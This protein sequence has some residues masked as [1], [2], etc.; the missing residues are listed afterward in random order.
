MTLERVV[1]PGLLPGADDAE[2]VGQLAGGSSVPA[3]AA[4]S[5]RRGP[6]R[7]EQHESLD[8]GLAPTRGALV[9]SQRRLGRHLRTGNNLSAG[10]VP[11]TRRGWL[12]LLRGRPASRW[13]RTGDTAAPAI[14][15]T[16]A[17]HCPQARAC[18]RVAAGR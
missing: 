9:G 14:T 3:R 1:V 12:A 4:G 8:H 17:S 18:R 10:V 11:P 7:A 2:A 5:G 6:R 15:T 16:G 13:R